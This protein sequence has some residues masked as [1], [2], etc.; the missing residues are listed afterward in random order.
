M[1]GWLPAYTGVFSAVTC[2]ILRRAQE[3]NHSNHLYTQVPLVFFYGHV[4][5][6]D[7]PELYRYLVDRVSSVL[8]RRAETSPEVRGTHGRL[9]GSSWEARG[10]LKTSWAAFE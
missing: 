2:A 5:P 10:H 1:A 3:L 4:T 6:N 7:A 9:V 8:D